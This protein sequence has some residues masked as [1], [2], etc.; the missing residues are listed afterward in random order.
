MIATR[1]QTCS[2]TVFPGSPAWLGII[3]AFKATNAAAGDP[4]PPDEGKLRLYAK[5]ESGSAAR[6]YVIDEVGTVSALARGVEP[7]RLNY[8]TD[9]INVSSATANTKTIS[10]G[11]GVVPDYVSVSTRENVNAIGEEGTAARTTS[12]FEARIHHRDAVTSFPVATT[13]EF[14]W[15]AI[16]S[17]E[18]APGP[19]VPDVRPVGDVLRRPRRWR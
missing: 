3:A 8:G 10:H 6:P 11:L 16:A 4:N 7:A 9:S 13:V 12:T 15:L 2:V 5:A 19:S 1:T 18:V 14:D 17:S